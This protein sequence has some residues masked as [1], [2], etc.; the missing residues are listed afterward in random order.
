MDPQSESTFAKLYQL[1]ERK[2]ANDPVRAL[3]FSNRT[4]KRLRQAGVVTVMDLLKMTPKILME[5]DGFG[6]GCLEE[7]DRTVSKLDDNKLTV[8][9]SE[10]QVPVPINPVTSNQ[11][12]KEL[13]LGEQYGMNPDEFTEMDVSLFSFSSRV[14]N[15][16]KRNSI[17]TVGLLLQETEK[18]LRSMRNFGKICMDEIEVKLLALRAESNEKKKSGAKYF[19]A[20]E[21]RLLASGDVSFLE[22][23]DISDSESG[24]IA[25]CIE[26][27]DALG[28]ELACACLD[29]PEQIVPILN[30]LQD[31]A[32][33]MKWQQDLQK[34]LQKVPVHRR[35][36]QA[37]AYI[38]TFTRR[39]EERKTLIEL[40][41]APGAPL[42]SIVHSNNLDGSSVSIAK[43]FL[44]WC[45]YDLHEEIAHLFSILYPNERNQ[46]VVQLRAQKKTLDQIGRQYGL[47]R[48]RI[49]QLESK[50]QRT[51]ND[52]QGRIKIISKINADKN[53]TAIV[54]PA[55]VAE[56]CT[57]NL[58]ELLFLLRGC[59]S[60]NFTYDKDL[61]V[62]IIGDDSVHERTDA[63]VEKLPDIIPVKDISRFYREAR[64]EYDLPKEIVDKAISE[65]YKLTGEVYHRITLSLANIYTEVIREFYPDGIDAYDTAT[66]AQFRKQISE[67]YG[68]IKLP[69]NDR[70]ITARIAGICILCGRGR[71]RL[72]QKQYI[73]KKLAQRI[74]DYIDDSDMDIFMT[75]TLFAV[76]ER[77][78]RKYGVDN[79]Y[80]LQGILHELYGEKFTFTRDYISKDPSITSIYPSIVN[81][82]WSSN[83]PVTKEQI[84]AQ[85]P[86]LP[87]IAI[88]IATSDPE[89]L[90][91]FGG[92][93]FHV[94]SLKISI[95]EKKYL[96]SIMR[97][98]V[99]DRGIHHT[100][101]VYAVVNAEKPEIFTRNGALY[102]FS[103]GS[104]LEYLFQNQYE[105]A[106]PFFARK[107]TD[108]KN[109]ADRLH[110]FMNKHTTITVTQISEFIRSSNINVPS[111]LD[112]IDECNDCFLLTDAEILQRI[113]N[114][115]VDCKIA[116]R[117]EALIMAEIT[118][119]V[120]IKDLTCWGGFPATK[121]RWTD[122]MVYSVL[123]KWGEKVEVAPSY[124]QFKYAVPVVAPVGKMNVTQYGEAIKTGEELQQDTTAVIHDLDHIDDILA[125]IL[126]DDILGEDLWDFEI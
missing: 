116:Q 42:E 4:A 20:E 47:T 32:Q 87:E 68:A 90:T 85:Y 81:F 94:D 103:A 96:D 61:D 107:G 91:Y 59:E 78:L 112:L 45:Q 72:K 79:K 89:I 118:E 71:Y 84:L 30:M 33:R 123:K 104:I 74:Y 56:Y 111:L 37:V 101:E 62:F 75:N 19:V 80:Y 14:S 1:D 6:V 17:S 34:I 15:M 21:H 66:I 122:W 24:F 23:V 92:T 44:I 108:I 49:R 95:D 106:R 67:K 48:E 18:Q 100:K 125:D 77:D 60:S 50:M 10:L 12:T 40:Y 64:N 105:F 102:P 8:T 117:I 76:F 98:I 31:F 11:E 65:T 29:K 5:I 126:S 7:I 58:Q 70:A 110:E 27:Q 114:T 41:P 25:R 13:T 22:G 113:E 52:R 82:I 124:P 46:Q 28:E 120:R 69:E 3:L 86:G 83:Y 26:A 36:N 55:N 9:F 115:G 38:N 121:I 88:S 63:F 54:T 109:P 99:A 73:P 43:R 93:F 97:Q 39:E 119:T 57:N 16:L 35:S 51:F 2:F 53:N